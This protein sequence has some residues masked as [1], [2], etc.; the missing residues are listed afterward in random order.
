MKWA[1]CSIGCKIRIGFFCVTGIFILALFLI[2]GAASD[3]DEHAGQAIG[4][5][6]LSV[7][8]LQ[9]EI[10]HLKWAQALG[11]FAHQH[12][13]VDL[14]VTADGTK[15]AFGKWFYGEERKKFEEGNPGLKTL[16]ASMEEP[17]AKLHE[18]AATIQ[19]LKREGGQEAAVG[20]YNG[21]TLMHLAKV[22]E[23]L[24]G[25]REKVKL[26][27]DADKTELFMRLGQLKI[28]L[29]VSSGVAI[30]LAVALSV[31]IARA[32]SGPVR[33]LASCA[34]QIAGGNLSLS[35]DLP[36]QDEIGQLS[37]SLSTMVVGLK[38]KISEADAKALE[39][40]ES[41][42]KAG[43][44]LAKAEEQER[45]V[46]GMLEMI[47]SI[48]KEAAGLSDS[49]SDYATRLAAQVD[50]VNRGARTQ[51][52]RLT[53]AA[54]AMDQMNATVMEVAKNA[55]EAASSA[56]R[57]QEKASEGARIVIESVRA[58]DRVSALSEQLRGN[59]HEL[60]GKAQSIGQVMNVIS[61][62]ADQ[63]NLLALNAAIE[64]ARAGEAG[65]GFAVVADEV[66]KLAEKTMGATQEVGA[67]IRA[68]QDSVKTSVTDMEEASKAV[69][70]SNE[71]AGQ[72]GDSLKEI[73]SLTGVNTQ[74][75][76]SIAAAA[77][78]QSSASEHINGSL[79]D[80]SGVAQETE[81]G[82]AETVDIVHNLASMAGKLNELIGQMDPGQG[83]G[84]GRG[85][86]RAA[87]AMPSGSRRETR[88]LQ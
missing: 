46:A 5:Y 50:Q 21:Q 30:L 87:R 76:Q 38:D 88:A 86:G 3:V 57:A 13:A 18:T 58:I 9:R 83:G 42:R 1:D 44:A 52:D 36:R 82:M 29:Y 16:I 23:I 62:I 55:G 12:G 22:Q 61:D 66:R 28:I 65:R 34:T 64:A 26:A 10:D 80:V 2:R 54:T 11:Q 59:M 75:V 14:A 67:T 51:K 74:N 15:C 69:A 56:A 6:D 79:T 43:E 49:L 78:E 32:I 47:R 85:S 37:S 24:Q 70:R 45:Q 71:L 39:A 53:E 48:A 7:T 72:S 33:S 68:I 60:G 17:H 31:V 8:L 35:C 73:V 4:E 25:L 81:A 27:I 41:A 77:E 40:D 63:T 19:K 84:N 20:V